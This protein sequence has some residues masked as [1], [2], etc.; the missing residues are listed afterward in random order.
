[1]PEGGV[2]DR[3]HTALNLSEARAHDDARSTM[4]YIIPDNANF[5]EQDAQDWYRRYGM[6]YN[7]SVSLA[8]KKAAIY[9]KM[10]E[11]RAVPRGAAFYL[12]A[13]L[14]AAG[15]DVYV[16]ENRAAESPFDVLGITG[17]F[18]ILGEFELAEVE[19]AEGWS[20][21]GITI[22][23]NHIEEVKDDTFSFASNYRSSFFI[24][25]SPITTFADVPADRKAEF[26]QLIL[27]LKRA[28]C[29][30]FLFVNYV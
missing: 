3:L 13:Q 12:Q 20:T 7:P 8:D 1:M 30:A 23:A 28:Q 6:I 15:F 18:A 10:G 26:R 19:L 17:G 2:L 22:V 27:R 16:Y 11:P 29:A 14:R 24:S 5:T 21:A 9:Q 25:G 4:D